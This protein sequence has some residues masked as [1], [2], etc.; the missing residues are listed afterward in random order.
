MD[1][2]LCI[3][4]LNVRFDTPDGEV[5]AVSDFSID[6]ARGETLAIVGESGSGKTQTFLA[7]MGLL[8]KNGRVEGTASLNSVDLL[9]LSGAELDKYRGREVTMVFQDPMTALNPSMRVSKQ[10]TETLVKH[11]KLGEAEAS[12][13]ALT[14]L[15]KVGIPEPRKRFQAYPHELS[16]G[17]RQRVMIAMALLCEPTVLIADEPT[18]ALDV[19]IQAQILDLFADLKNEFNTALVVITHDLGVVAGLA[20]RIGVMYAGKIVEEGNVYEVFKHPLHP[21]TRALMESTPRVDLDG[22]DIKPIPGNPPNLQRLPHGCAFAVR[23]RFATE[24]CLEYRPPLSE[25]AGQRR[26]ACFYSAD[27]SASGVMEADQ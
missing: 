8:A 2:A 3:Q 26:S 18:T 13:I 11:K 21:Y 23:C 14:M 5:V 19:T 12:E 10:L 17:M 20:D 15:E 16:G 1:Q 9:N 6:I 4:N 27:F 24:K 7:V 22:A 25:F